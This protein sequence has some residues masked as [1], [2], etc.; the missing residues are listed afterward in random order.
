MVSTKLKLST[1]RKFQFLVIFAFFCTL[2]LGTISLYSF[3]RF[4]TLFQDFQTY[5]SKE[6]VALTLERNLLVR[7]KMIAQYLQTNNNF[8]IRAIEELHTSIIAD[9]DQLSNIALT[10]AQQELVE[11]N[12]SAYQNN[13]TSLEALFTLNAE[14]TALQ[15][16]KLELESQIVNSLQTYLLDKGSSDPPIEALLNGMINFSQLSNLHF[17]SH[18]PLQD[19]GHQLTV[20]REL[21]KKA[22]DTLAENSSAV[23]T[24]QKNWEHYLFLTN[25]LN[26]LLIFYQDRARSYTHYDTGNMIHHLE[27][28]EKS[29]VAKS[30]D[31]Y[32][33][34]EGK[35]DITRH[36]AII[37]GLFTIVTLAWL[38]VALSQLF[39]IKK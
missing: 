6:K 34:W 17:A 31:L 22:S 7:E 13:V 32:E 25:K 38:M 27:A 28:L 5:T 24:L 36:I 4:Y 23:E 8:Y 26:Q 10:T 9:F 12:L 29:F 16:Q 37:V 33:R 19:V 2:G 20:L 21:L 18:A 11:E 3:E 30:S 1:S 39:S 35:H 15:K 14:L